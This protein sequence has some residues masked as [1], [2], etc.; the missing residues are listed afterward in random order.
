[1]ETME[2]TLVMEVDALPPGW[3]VLPIEDCLAS[4]NGRKKLGQGWSPQCEKEASPSDEKWGVL[5]TT[6]VQAGQFLQEENKLLPD[7][8][9]ARPQI[10]V[11][12]GDLLTTCAG[13]RSR[14]G[15]TCLVRET[16]P[17]LMISGKMYRYRADK[18]VVDTK[19]L[20]AYMQTQDAWDAIDKMKTGGSDS[21]L[22]LTHERFLQLPIPLAPLPE[23]RRIVAA[24]ETQLGRLDAAVARLHAAKAQLKRYK[25]AVLKAAVEGAEIQTEQDLGSMC[26]LI[27]SGSRGWAA[28]YAD[29]GDTFIRAQNLKHDTLELDD[30]AYVQLPEKV[31]GLRTQV[32]R[33]DILITITGANVTKTALVTEDL[34]GRAFVNQHIALVRLKDPSQAPFVFRWIISPAH[35]R[36]ILE[37]LAYGAG[38]PGLNLSH[39][40]DLQIPL[41]PLDEQAEVVER[42][43]LIDQANAELESTLDTQLLHSTRLRQ[44]VLKRAFEGRLG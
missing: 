22:N 8:L 12:A 34:E 21:G 2:K 16:R 40:R 37:K 25:Q 23:Q 17:R 3:Q 14:C 44:S 1:M 42:L 31:D 19:Y 13:P 27:T 30:I 4:I 32:Q 15:V 20:E 36:G 11:Q 29:S 7:K 43:D 6:A 35:G 39:I 41:P 28:Y 38:K 26:D 33:N 18:N 9:E 24:I 10:E 5:K